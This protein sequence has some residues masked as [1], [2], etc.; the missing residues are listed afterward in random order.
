MVSKIAG[1]LRR[2]RIIVTTDAIRGIDV[3]GCGRFAAASSQ[4]HLGKQS[5]SKTFDSRN[6]MMIYFFPI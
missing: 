3:F 5:G 6:M 2:H 4:F 1:V